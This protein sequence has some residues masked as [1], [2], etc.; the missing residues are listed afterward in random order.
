MARIL[1][2]ILLITAA[3]GCYPPAYYDYWNAPATRR[4]IEEVDRQRYY[5][6]ELYY[7]PYY[8]PYPYVYPFIFSFSYGAYSHHHRFGD[9]HHLM[10]DRGSR[11]GRHRLHR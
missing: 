7:A 4:Y 3:A 5:A 1:F 2:L 6:P 11:E 9:R 8:Y 10:P